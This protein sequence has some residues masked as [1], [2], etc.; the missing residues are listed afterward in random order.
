MCVCMCFQ[1]N[2]NHGWKKNI[3]IKHENIPSIFA[4]YLHDQQENSQY[5]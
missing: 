2:V 4:C 5:T 3:K 1:E